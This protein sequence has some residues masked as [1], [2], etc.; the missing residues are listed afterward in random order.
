MPLVCPVCKAENAGASCRRCKADLSMLIGLADRRGD[1]LAAA[2]QAYDQARLAD[3]R[4]LAVAAN[5]DRQDG[6]SLR[7]VAM[8]QLLHGDFGEAWRAYRALNPH[9]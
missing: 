7:W 2:R 4:R 8:L 6:E 1:L 3:A 5:D 9:G